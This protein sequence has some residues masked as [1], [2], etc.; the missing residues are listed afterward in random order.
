MGTLS[1]SAATSISAIN[2]LYDIFQYDILAHGICPLFLQYYNRFFFGQFLLCVSKKE[3][4]SY[5]N[6]ISAEKFSNT[7][8]TK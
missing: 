2:N 3:V 4:F 7:Y 8:I 6:D 1:I 5:E